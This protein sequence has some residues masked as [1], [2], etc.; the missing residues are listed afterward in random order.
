MLSPDPT[1]HRQVVTAARS[2]LA[3]DPEAPISRIATEAGVSRAT[4]YRHFGSRQA[5]LRAIEI[6][7]PV[8]ARE[9][10]L[11]AAVELLGRG[12]GLQGFSMEELATAAGVSRATVYRLFP[13]KATLFREIVRQYSPFEPAMAVLQAHG[14]EPPEV[15]IPL[16]TRTFATIGA[17]RTG[18]LRGVLVEA[19]AVTPEAE[20]GVQPLLPEALAS[21]GG[22]LLRQMQAGR[23]RPMHPLLALQALLGP[24]FIHVLTRPLAER[25]VG[26]DMPIADVADQL[27]AGILEGLR[28]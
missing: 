27:T 15:V 17:E 28:Q 21:I 7:P 18:I 6:E 22:Y 23:I 24:I 8:P 9:R 12:A 14:D 1:I 13:T 2:L 26:F 10:V 19:L 25:V 5:L 20:T 4:F 11:A 16:L 3:A